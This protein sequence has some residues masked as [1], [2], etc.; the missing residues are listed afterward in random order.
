[1][2]VEKIENRDIRDESEHFK[3]ISDKG[4][5]VEFSTSLDVLYSSNAIHCRITMCAYD[6][7][8]PGEGKIF[9]KELENY[10]RDK[11]Y[12]FIISNVVSGA[13]EKILRD[14]GYREYYAKISDL[15]GDIIQSFEK[16]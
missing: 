6:W 4:G 12:R 3:M 9:L 11:R 15:D 1:M 2:K 14:A 16:L 13:L 7:N 10:A 5:Y 8:C